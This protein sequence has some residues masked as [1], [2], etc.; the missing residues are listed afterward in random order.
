MN[1]KFNTYQTMSFYKSI[2]TIINWID[3]DKLELTSY[4][5]N[6]SHET[7]LTLSKTKKKNY[8]AQFSI[9]FMLKDEI[10]KKTKKIQVNMS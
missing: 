4:I 1:L 6:P 3:L 8:N 7:I 9:N 5:C 10:K 2:E